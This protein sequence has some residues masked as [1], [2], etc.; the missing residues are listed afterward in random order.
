MSLGHIGLQFSFSCLLHEFTQAV[1]FIFLLF[2]SIVSLS[3]V[4]NKINY[5]PGEPN[6]CSIAIVL[7]VGLEYLKVSRESFPGAFQSE[8]SFF[9]NWST[10]SHFPF[11]FFPFSLFESTF[12]MNAA[13]LF[14]Q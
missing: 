2:W 9:L 14:D 13:L 4:N 6:T 7:T 5:V 8:A 1:Q 10:F 11:V 3:V 12:W